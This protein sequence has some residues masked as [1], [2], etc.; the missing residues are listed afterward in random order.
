MPDEEV[1]KGKIYSLTLYLVQQTIVK[2]RQLALS[3]I[4][5]SHKNFVADIKFI[6]SGVKVDRKNPPPDGRSPHFLSVAEDGLVCIWDSRPVE[7]EVLRNINAQ[8]YIWKP[9]LQINLIRQDGSGELGLSRILFHPKQQTTTFWGASDEGDLLS[10]DW[11]VK[12]PPGATEEQ[13]KF[14]EY[15]KQTYDCDRC[16]RPALAL[17][18]SPFFEDLILTVT[19]FYFCIWKTSIDSDQPIFRSA[20]TFG[21]HNTCGAFSPTRPGVI[22]I[23][24]TDGIDVWDFIDQSN[25]PSLTLNFATS[26][27]TFFKFQYFKH[28]DRKQYMAYGDE[29]D[30]TLFLYEVPVNLRNP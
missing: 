24:K 9:Y 25:K 13:A 29:Q 21:S 16:Y 8:D 30:G 17:E 11:S 5:Q 18:R 15:V 20:C 14:A 10:I 7:K 6:P 28:E 4:V 26:A 1:D 27:I 23:T 22:F 12:P 2:L 3:S 19:D